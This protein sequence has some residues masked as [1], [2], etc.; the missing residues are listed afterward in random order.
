[1]E[2]SPKDLLRAQAMMLAKEYDF[3]KVSPQ[4]VDNISA[5]KYFRDSQSVLFYWPMKS[6]VDLCPLLELALDLN[7]KCYLP[8]SS[9]NP[10]EIKCSF[11]PINSIHD[12]LSKG[13]FGSLEPESSQ[14]IT[15]FNT[16]D[17]IFVPGL[18]FDLAGNR[19]GKGKGYYDKLI[20]ELDERSITLGILP[21]RFL[22]D[23]LE[24]LD[25]WDK[26]VKVIATE[27]KVFSVG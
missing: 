24:P 12:S 25:P 15:N 8:K 7:K 5:S 17:L 10:K 1:M 14:I 26:P 27:E 18:L 13:P 9:T 23:G 11:A 3:A 16:L 4:I 22:V 6:E 20:S 19:L 21:E 2:T